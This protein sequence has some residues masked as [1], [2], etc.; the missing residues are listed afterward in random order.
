MPD[1]DYGCEVKV[2]TVEKLAGSPLGMTI[3]GGDDT[4]FPSDGI[5]I[6]ALARNG[7]GVSLQLH[8]CRRRW[9][10]KIPAHF[11]VRL[12]RSGWRRRTVS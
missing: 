12:G 8:Y 9:P 7:Y 2:V 3:S 1:V 5:V 6:R 11:R 10:V 4:P